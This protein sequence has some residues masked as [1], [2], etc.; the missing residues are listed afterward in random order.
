MTIKYLIAEITKCNKILLE[1]WVALK[2]CKL[3]E[4]KAF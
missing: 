1:V 2:Y 4:M 3:N